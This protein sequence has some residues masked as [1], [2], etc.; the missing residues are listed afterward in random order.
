[1]ENSKETLVC[2]ADLDKSLYDCSCASVVYDSW[3]FSI[4]HSSMSLLVSAF[5]YHLCRSII[6]MLSDCD[7][8]RDSSHATLLD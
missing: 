7:F 4:Q 8:V 5:F 6:E 1:M 3:A 2:H